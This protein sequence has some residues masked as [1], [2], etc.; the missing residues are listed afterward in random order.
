ME[1][2]TTTKAELEYFVSTKKLLSFQLHFPSDFL[3]GSDLARSLSKYDSAALLN[4]NSSMSAPLNL[5]RRIFSTFSTFSRLRCS[6]LI[7]FSIE[8][9]DSTLQG[10][11]AK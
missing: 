8:K 7:I 10:K 11:Q 2:L 5:I 4:G 1:L 3:F 6:F 9:P